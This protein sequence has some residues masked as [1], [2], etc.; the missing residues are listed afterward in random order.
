MEELEEFFEIGREIVCYRD[1][2][3]LADNIKYY[4]T[5]DEER[6]KIRRAGYQRAVRDHSWHKRF[7]TAFRQ[8][9]LDS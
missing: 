2:V 9:G 1:K 6:E 7:E 3:D 4:L 5:H 8:I